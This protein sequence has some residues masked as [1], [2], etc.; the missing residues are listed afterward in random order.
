MYF[1]MSCPQFQKLVIVSGQVE[2]DHPK[3][4]QPIIYIQR[5]TITYLSIEMDT[6]VL[7]V[8]TFHCAIKSRFALFNNGKVDLHSGYCSLYFM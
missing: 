7:K 2:V 4:E 8:C 5:S 3:Q 1:R 6:A